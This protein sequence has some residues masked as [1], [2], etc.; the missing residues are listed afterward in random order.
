[1]T[2]KAIEPAGAGRAARNSS[3]ATT[4]AARLAFMSAVPRPQRQPSRSVG[5]NGAERHASAGPVG[6]TSVC[7]AK[8]SSGPWSPRRAQKFSTSPKRMRSIGEAGGLEPLDH[9]RLAAGILRGDRCA[10]YERLS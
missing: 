8:Q 3:T 9:Q 6:T 4:I 7:P 2:R 10:L 5:T 1:V